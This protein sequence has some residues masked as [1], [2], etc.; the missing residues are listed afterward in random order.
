MQRLTDLQAAI[1]RALEMQVAEGNVNFQ[2]LAER[3][4]ISRETVREHLDAIAR[5]GYLEI[6]S[7]G[8]GRNPTVR[9]LHTGVP[10]VGHIAAGPLS[11]ALEYPEG[12]LRL[13]TYP[14]KFGLRVQGDSMADA[15]QHGDVVL[16]KKRPHKSGEVC[17]VRVDRSEATLKYLDLYVNHPA[18]V[19]LRP[20]NPEYPN[21]EVEADRVV[22]D[23]VFVGLLRGEVID[24]LMG[25]TEMN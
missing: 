8:R 1:L 19:L 10:V 20:H 6:K 18:T 3:F 24:E 16:L 21:T 23:G 2:G 13:P 5:K 12:Y 14:G 15:I 25:S 22:V 4:G 9:L 11:E 17:A 7:R